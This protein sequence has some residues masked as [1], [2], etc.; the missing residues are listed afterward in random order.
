MKEQIL[1]LR[2]EA[3]AAIATAPDVATI[4]EMRVR[5]LGKK[6]DLSLALGGL[7]K[8]PSIEERKVM[9]ALGNEVKTAISE[10]LD[11]REA[12][13]GQAEL[14]ARLAAESID[15]TLPGRP[16]EQGH[17]HIMNQVR[18]KIE[19]IF[20]AMGYE[21]AESRQVETDW[22]NFEALNIPKGHPARDAQDSFFIS[23]E[24]LL[25]THTSNTQIRYMLEVAKGR[26]PVKIICPGRVFRRDFE[27]ATHGSVFHQVEGLVIGKGITMA[28]LKGALTEMARGMFGPNAGIRLR[29]SYFPFTEPS[30]EM[31]ISCPFCQGNGCR[32]CKQ[33]GWVEIGGSGMVHPNVLRAGGYDPEAVSGWAFGYGIER[34]AMLV[35]QIED[36]RHFINGDMRFLKQF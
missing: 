29:P 27:D 24:V 22:Y 18:T 36:L 4:Q 14:A 13:L 19:E 7:G 3:L 2:D 15:V 21:V 12:E 9:G 11:A 23:D 20:I 5:Y 31:D 28:H 30:A 34:V 25:R 8:L 10:A 17:L 6:S 33:S 35:Y 32:V 1:Q 26:T 16:V